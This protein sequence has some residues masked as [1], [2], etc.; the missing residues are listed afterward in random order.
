MILVSLIFLITVLNYA[1][2]KIMNAIAFH[3]D[4]HQFNFEAH[5]FNNKVHY[6]KRIIS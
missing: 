4:I 1:S 6:A 5:A 2:E 3:P